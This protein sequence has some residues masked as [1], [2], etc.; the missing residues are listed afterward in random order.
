MSPY[1]KGM[2]LPVVREQVGCQWLGGSPRSPTV[3]PTPHGNLEIRVPHDCLPHPLTLPWGEMMEE[4][5]APWDTGKLETPWRA[6][7]HR[8]N[9]GMWRQRMAQSGLWIGP[10]PF[11]WPAGLKL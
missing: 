8:P 5:G 2:L 4:R 1:P 3:S 7:V 10:A 9:P 11:I 6:T